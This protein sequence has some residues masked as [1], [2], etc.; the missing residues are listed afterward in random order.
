MKSYHL[1]KKFDIIYVKTNAS[2]LGDL[3]HKLRKPKIVFPN[4]CLTS[5]YLVNMP[6]LLKVKMN[7][8]PQHIA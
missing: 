3:S 7:F 5:F 2:F 1:L 6:T 4:F 8:N